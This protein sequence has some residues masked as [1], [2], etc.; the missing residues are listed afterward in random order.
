LAVKLL[1]SNGNLRFVAVLTTHHWV[2]SWESWILSTLSHIISLTSSL[3]LFSLL[4]LGLFRA[5]FTLVGAPGNRN[6]EALISN[7]KC[8]LWIFSFLLS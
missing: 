7:N 3:T 5:G 6:G 2:I 1:A 8:S 4:R